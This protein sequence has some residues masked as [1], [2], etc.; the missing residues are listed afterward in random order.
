MTGGEE[1]AAENPENYVTGD[2]SVWAEGMGSV[3]RVWP[4]GPAGHVRQ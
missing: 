2:D 4:V 3:W 1:V